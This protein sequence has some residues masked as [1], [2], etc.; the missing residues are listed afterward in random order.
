MFVSVF[1]RKDRFLEARP[2]FTK[3]KTAKIN[4]NFAVKVGVRRLEL[5]PL[6]AFLSMIYCFLIFI[7]HLLVQ[8]E[9]EQFLIKIKFFNGLH[10]K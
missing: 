6:Y 9:K 1:G 10:K 2:G 3:T 5:I 8:I 4:I 7:V